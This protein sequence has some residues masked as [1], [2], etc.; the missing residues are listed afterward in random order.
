MKKIMIIGILLVFSLVS[1][2][3]QTT[4]N[5]SEETSLY[6][7]E[8]TDTTITFANIQFQ[9]ESAVLLESEMIKLQEIAE[10]LTA[11]P[12]DNLL[13]V[14]HAVLAGTQEGR[15]KLSDDRANAVASYLVELGVKT[16]EQMFT[17]GVGADEQIVPDDTPKNKAR[18]RRVEITLIE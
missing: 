17:E 10:I 8:D 3:C 18:N 16:Y 5:V 2:S 1:F 15:Q 9:P 14:G 11:F 4:G 13:I 12:E 6:E 7:G